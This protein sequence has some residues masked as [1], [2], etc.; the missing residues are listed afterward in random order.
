MDG[1]VRKP[2]LQRWQ[3]A[4]LLSLLLHAGAFWLCFSLRWGGNAGAGSLRSA[5]D[6]RVS[7][8]QMK[9]SFTLVEAT[10]GRRPTP[11]VSSVPP[12]PAPT[13]VRTFQPIPSETAPNKPAASVAAW[14]PGAS[15]E[16]E[17]GTR[18]SPGSR[19]AS[20]VAKG[21]G[22]GPTTFF[23]IPTQAHRVVYMIDHSASMGLNGS[24]ARAKEEL[25][26]S[27]ATLPR[28]VL[29]QIVIYNRKAEILP[30]TSGSHLA[31]ATPAVKRC[32]RELLEDLRAEGGTEYVSAFRC[33]LAL[34]PEVIF[35][36]TDGDNLT[37]DQIQAVNQL[38]R[39]RAVI[40]AIELGGTQPRRAD[41]ALRLLSR[42]NQG[43]YQ[44][45]AKSK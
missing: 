26:A 9:V 28:D 20:T 43:T 13:A 38:N 3:L 39:A 41:S 35:F 2:I 5:I 32:V 18:Q 24:L 22:T 42:A 4:F 14:Q 10:T 21:A 40:H 45:V 17:E 6:T 1:P 12:A 34:R 33:A 16:Q 37:L 25:I 29:I 27:L 8:A 31:A 11:T 15:E 19:N 36:L 7:G 23:Q 44:F 30:L